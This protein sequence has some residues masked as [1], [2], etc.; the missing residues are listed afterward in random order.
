MRFMI[1]AAPD[2]NAPKTEGAPPSDEL[3]AA[4]MK[5]NED[6]T[7]AG[8]LVTAE[9]LNPAQE[10]ARVAN[11][12]GKRV[13]LDGPFVESKELVGGFY[14]IDVNSRE[15]AIEWALRCPTGIG[16]DD[17]LTILP[18]TGAEDIPPEMMAIV[19]KA[20]PTWLRTFWKKK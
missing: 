8:V 5:F 9:G 1:C 6:M 4:Y 7:K 12:G 18:M 19:E 11:K 14:L 20:A 16:H 15:E 3:I 13:V 2:P 17:I 10:G